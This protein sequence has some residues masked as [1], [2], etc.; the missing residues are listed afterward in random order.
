M[1]VKEI[2]SCSVRTVEPETKLVEV[3]SLM[4]LYRYSGLPVVKDG[5]LVG[6]IAEKDVLHRL[7]PK[8]EDL[9]EGWAAID[10]DQMMGEYKDVLSLK[11]SD[12]M[13][14]SVITVPPDMH[15]LR[16]ATVMVR[17]KFRRIPVAEGDTLVG[18]LSLGDVHKA[19]FHANISGNLTA[20]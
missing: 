11:V 12:L 19:I 2:M 18:M 17:H 6:I 8:L 16:A 14:P 7:F 15:I 10:L 1:Q 5:K 13:S 20:G 4:C 9:M 3:A